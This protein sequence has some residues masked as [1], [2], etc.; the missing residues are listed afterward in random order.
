M[1][2]FHYQEELLFYK[3]FKLHFI[4][5]LLSI[6]CNNIHSTLVTGSACIRQLYK[7]IL[8][9]FCLIDIVKELSFFLESKE[10][11]S[12]QILTFVTLNPGLAVLCMNQNSCRIHLFHLKARH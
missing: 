11:N 5:K 10:K 3:D 1:F 7:I 9:I 2:L 6:I 12:Y 8:I 4:L